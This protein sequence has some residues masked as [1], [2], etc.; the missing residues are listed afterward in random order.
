[1]LTKPEVAEIWHNALTDID[2]E[3]AKVSLTKW[4]MTEKW[5]PTIADIRETVVNVTSP[6]IKDWSEAWAEV[7]KAV[8]LVG[9]Y[10]E[11]RAMARLDEI[12]R[13]TVERFGFG[14]LCA[15]ESDNRETV[16]AQFRDMYN[17][18]A[19]R[20][21]QDAQMPMALKDRIN[22]FQIGVPKNERRISSPE[23]RARRW[24]EVDEEKLKFLQGLGMEIESLDDLQ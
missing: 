12:T 6:E 24:K 1:M 11:D 4:V 18:I 21:K 10:A 22:A 19:N 7:N 9:P 8:R 15:M 3:V 2:Y 16:R 20:H 14:N 23:E 5:M 13:E 17:Q